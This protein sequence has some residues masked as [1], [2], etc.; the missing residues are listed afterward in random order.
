[1]DAVCST[2]I[3]AAILGGGA[4][5]RRRALQRRIGDPVAATGAGLTLEDVEESEPVANLVGRGSAL[6]VVGHS[7]SGNRLS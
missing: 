5:L 7:T 3:G 2:R 6:V 4:S 1:M